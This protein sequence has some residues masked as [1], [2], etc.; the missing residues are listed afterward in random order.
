MISLRDRTGRLSVCHDSTHD[1]H[2]LSCSTVLVWISGSA[3]LEYISR[4][5][6]F[7]LSIRLWESRGS[8]WISAARRPPGSTMNSIS[9]SK[10]GT[11]VNCSTSSNEKRT[12]IWEFPFKDLK[13]VEDNADSQAKK[14]EKI[15]EKNARYFDWESIRQINFKLCSL[16]TPSLAMPGISNNKPI[17]FMICL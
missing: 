10:A 2:F 9:S 14:C 7:H 13:I 5:N 4:A 16:D 15:C 17:R 8:H 12:G 11:E 6:S 3:V 1:R